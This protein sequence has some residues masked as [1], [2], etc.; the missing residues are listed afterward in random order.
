MKNFA[1]I[2]VS[3]KFVDLMYKSSTNYIIVNN[4]YRSSKF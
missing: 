1:T 3:M 4:Y 2:K